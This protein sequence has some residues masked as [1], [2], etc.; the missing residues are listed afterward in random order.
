[1]KHLLKEIGTWIIGM[2]IIW[3]PMLGIVICN[4]IFKLLGV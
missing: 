3:V 1:M 4:T 2:S